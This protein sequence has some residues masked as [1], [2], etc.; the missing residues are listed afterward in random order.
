MLSPKCQDMAFGGEY[1]V[2]I[3]LVQ[4]ILFVEQ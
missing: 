3:V 2:G 4:R 1:V